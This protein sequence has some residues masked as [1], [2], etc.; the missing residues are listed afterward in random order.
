MHGG[1]CPRRVPCRA[2]S[3]RWP[4]VLFVMFM[5]SWIISRCL[6][7]PLVVIRATLIDSR[8]SEPPKG[9]VAQGDRVGCVCPRAAPGSSARSARWQDVP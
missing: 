5:I 8:V 6:Y 1:Q 9:A 4:D 3:K 7:F 2:G